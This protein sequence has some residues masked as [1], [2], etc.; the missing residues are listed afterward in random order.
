MRVTRHQSS[1]RI[2]LAG[3]IH[4]PRVLSVVAA[5]WDEHGLFA[6]DEANRV[7]LWC[8][9]YHRKYGKPPG[10]HVAHLLGLWAERTDVSDSA[11]DS[12]D[13]LLSSVLEDHP[14]ERL[15]NHDVIVDEAGRHFTRVRMA[16]HKDRIEA[17]LDTDQL[18]VA[19]EAFQSYRKV[20][21]GAHEGINL[22]IDKEAVYSGFPDDED[23]EILIP[24]PGALGKFFSL[25]LCRDGF[26][27]VMGA[28]KRGK[29]WW[30]ID[31]A[32][33]AMLN[34][35]RV[36]FFQAGDLSRKQVIRR[37]LIRTVGR[38]LVAKS[39]PMSVKWPTAIDTAP[40]R[41]SRGVD[42]AEVTF[43]KKTFDRP[44]NRREA[45]KACREVMQDKVKAA[46]SYFKLVVA[47]NYTLTVPALRTH[48]EGWALNEGWA[49]DVVVID[50][51]DILA[52]LNPKKEERE[53]IK[54][55][56]QM[57]RRLSTELHCLVLVG[58]QSDTA[59]F[60]C[61]VLTRSNFVGDRRT[62]DNVT[63]CVGLNQFGKEDEREIIR[64]NWVV[65]R[66]EE[67]RVGRCVHTARCLGLGQPAVLSSL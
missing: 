27:S 50:Y 56:W 26:V 29:S 28:S 13:R 40:Y 36:A 25:S 49:P 16:R 67:S 4:N 11:R 22:F 10:P 23:S 1:E 2:I 60:K 18:D 24:Y 6:S 35:K 30:L 33:R 51:A 15:D 42:P 41:N 58:T 21:V 54:D 46:D 7:G 12:T 44:F 65:L 5:K 53:Q 14:P 63:G 52:P 9:E 45:W 43:E 8:V 3:M 62:L 39:W 47:G 17:A 32:Y 61:R 66:E 19:E 64:L 31:M 48:V 34:R 38:P 55:N 59:S 37:L 57:L 20:E